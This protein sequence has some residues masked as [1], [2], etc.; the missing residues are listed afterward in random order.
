ME[1]P[2]ATLTIT[3][4]ADRYKQLQEIA[5][6]YNISLEDLARVSVEELLARPDDNFQRIVDYVLEKNDELY[7]RLA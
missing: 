5:T 2:M 7:R 1:A 4:S 6:R 3:L